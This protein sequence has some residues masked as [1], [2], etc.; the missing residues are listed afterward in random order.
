MWNIRGY[1]QSTAEQ[2]ALCAHCRVI[3]FA[4]QESGKVTHTNEECSDRADKERSEYV[5]KECSERTG[6]R[7][8]WIRQQGV[9]GTFGKE[10]SIRT[11][12]VRSKHTVYGWLGAPTNSAWGAPTRKYS[13][14]ARQSLCSE[15]LKRGFFLF[16]SLFHVKRSGFYVIHGDVLPKKLF[17]A[18]RRAFSRKVFVKTACVKCLRNLFIRV[19]G[20]QS[21]GKHLAL[22]LPP[23]VSRNMRAKCS[24]VT[25]M[26]AFLWW[27]YVKYSKNY[28]L[29]GVTRRF[30]EVPALIARVKRFPALSFKMFAIFYGRLYRHSCKKR[31]QMLFGNARIK[32]LRTASIQIFPQA[33]SC[34]VSAA[35]TSVRARVDWKRQSAFVK[36]S[37]RCPRRGSHGCSHRCSSRGSCR[38]SCR[39]SHRSR[40]CSHRGSRRCSLRHCINAGIDWVWSACAGFSQN[41]VLFTRNGYVKCR[42]KEYGSALLQ[43]CLQKMPVYRG[44]PE[45]FCK[46][47]SRRCFGSRRA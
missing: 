40:K 14:S 34:R 36:C 41:F 4:W 18:D 16:F 19:V 2:G 32:Y 11:G 13:G 31:R 43:K 30:C 17:F 47:S 37:R 44:S 22:F 1:Y 26:Q 23:N 29:E 6:K 35:R 45:F 27:I 25:F 24:S 38:G 20:V 12:K 15:H 5:N 28:L 7:A 3:C 46:M 33:V 42:F 10:R 8:L 39:C 21:L 9:F